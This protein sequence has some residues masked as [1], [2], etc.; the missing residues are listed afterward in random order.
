MTKISYINNRS[1]NDLFFLG[2]MLKS[3]CKRTLLYRG[4]WQHYL[5]PIGPHFIPSNLSFTTNYLTFLPSQPFS[6][7]SSINHSPSDHKSAICAVEQ[8]SRQRNNSK[9]DPCAASTRDLA[10][11]WENAADTARWPLFP[12]L[13]AY[14]P[15]PPGVKIAVFPLGQ[16]FRLKVKPALTQSAVTDW[17]SLYRLR[18]CQPRWPDG[19]THSEMNVEKFFI[20]HF[21]RSLHDCIFLLTVEQVLDISPFYV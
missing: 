6:L 21:L 19:P 1:W 14:R 7:L 11:A 20:E 13:W 8:P 9:S 18:R 4:K 15:D 5:K 10:K 3:G 2:E 16:F 12:D 17:A